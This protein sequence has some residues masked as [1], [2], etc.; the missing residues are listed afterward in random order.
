M[1]RISSATVPA[2]VLLL[3]I[4]VALPAAAQSANG[5]FTFQFDNDTKTIEFNVKKAG[6]SAKGS[7]T[8]TGVTEF[9]DQDVDGSGDFGPSGSVSVTLKVDFDCFRMSANGKRAAASG[10]VTQSSIPGLVGR[11][12]LLTVE[13]NGEGINQPEPDRFTW[14]LYRQN[15]TGWVPSDAELTS[16]LGVGLSWLA[17]DA[18]RIPGDPDNPVASSV[19]PDPGD[20]KGFS[21]GA[22]AVEDLIHGNGN[23]QVK[24]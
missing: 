7:M 5:S 24:P 21:L 8:F 19:A 22:Y 2:F 16:D 13:D 14:G 12:G 4:C 1:N 15:A 10:L 20:C 6:N 3:A 9:S 18:E 23:I 17:D 11:R